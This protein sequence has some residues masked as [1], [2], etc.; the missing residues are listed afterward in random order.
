MKVAFTRAATADL[1]SL[2]SY[3]AQRSPMA[4]ARLASRLLTASRSLESLP[5]RGRPGQQRGTRELTTVK[6]Y[7]IVYRVTSESVQ[8]LRIW[9]GR[10]A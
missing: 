4:A 7:V 3:L 2:R 1:T 6:P 9:H 5:C 8:V 10:Q